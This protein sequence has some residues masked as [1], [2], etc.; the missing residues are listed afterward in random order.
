MGLYFTFSIVLYYILGIAIYFAIKTIFLKKKT[1]TFKLISGKRYFRYIKLI[2]HQ[3]V[4]LYIIIFSIISNTIVIFQNQKY[5]NLYKDEQTITQEAVIIS[6]KQEKEYYNRYKIKIAGSNIYLYLRINKKITTSLEYGD[7]IKFSGEFIKAT[8][9]R[10]YGGFDYQEYLKTQKIYGSVKVEELEVVAKKKANPVFTIANQIT[11]KI[12]QKIDYNFETEQASILK[13][14]LLGDTSQIEEKMQENFRVSNISHILAVSGMHI[15]YLMIGINLLFQSRIGKRKTSFFVIIFLLFYMFLTGFSPSVVRAG[16]MGILVIG[17]GIFYRKNDIWTSLAISLFLILIDNPFL[18]TNMGL[19]FSYLGTIGII[20]FHSNVLQF[21][22]NIK[23]RDQKWKYKFSRKLI[24]SIAKIKEILA[25]T[26]SAQLAILPVMLYHSNLF[27]TYFLLT[28]LLVSLIIGP[29]I[30][31]SMITIVFSFF[32]PF[33]TKILSFLLN[34]F[35]QILIG[36]S[37]LGNLPFAKIYI[38]TPKAWAILLY[39]F[40]ILISN[41]IYPLYY[42]KKLTNTQMRARNLIA[43]AKYKFIQDKK[44]HLKIMIII[45]ILF[46]FIQFMPKKLEIHFVDVGQGDCTFMETPYG[47]TILIDGGGSLSD[48]FDV[49]QSTL[50]PYILDRGYTKIDYIFISHFDQDH[51]RF[52]SIFIK[53]NKSKKCNNRKTI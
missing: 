10:N 28:N 7:K 29:I 49:G 53:R 19:Q 52:Y 5:Q 20:L 15:T 17:A 34:Y 43:L 40:F 30:I 46:L 21:L 47:K 48:E 42:L 4:I 2:F 38:P 8:S 44:K 31:I 26:I 18:I 3:K 1:R 22:K 35:I 6:E 51:V 9:Q 33:I 24:L 14:I 12:K 50:L 36:I 32:L 37:N 13:G 23:I 11:S 39:Y 16:I 41:F 25:V 45:F 27:G